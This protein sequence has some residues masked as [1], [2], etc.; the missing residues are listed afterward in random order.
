M[1][2]QDYL[3]VY[4]TLRRGFSHRMANVLA[5]DAEFVGLGTVQG[6]LYDLGSY[7]GVTLSL[8]TTDNVLGDVYKLRSRNQTLARL[9]RYEGYDPA[10]P[11]RS[12]YVRKSVPISMTDGRSI[13]AWVY[14]YNRPVQGCE[15]IESGDYL[16]YLDVGRYQTAGR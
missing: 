8:R 9:D 2:N 12:L 15:L 13:Q 6:R 5:Q 3:F 4:G 10:R 11:T 7:P 1:S 14:L 16:Q